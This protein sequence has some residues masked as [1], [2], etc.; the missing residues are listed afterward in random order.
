MVGLNEDENAVL[1][2]TFQE[3]RSQILLLGETKGEFGGSL[4]IKALHGETTGSLP[5]FD[6]KSELAL[7]DIV[8]EANKKGLL[9][10]AK[11][12]NVGGIAIALSKMA[13]VS[14]KGIVTNVPVHKSNYIFDESQSRAL[15]EVSSENLVAVVHMAAS[16]GIFVTNIGSVG[17]DKVKINDV[18]LP[19]EVV[20]DVY[21]NTFEKTIEQDI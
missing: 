10:S 11:D 12:V 8:I 1:P 9:K 4:Y 3:E 5:K 2:S 21:F 6:Y 14:G 7:W 13:A 18:E 16:L 19:L 20:K 17:G 15:V